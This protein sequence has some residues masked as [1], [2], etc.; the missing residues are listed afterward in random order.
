M[1]L[2]EMVLALPASAIKALGLIGVNTIEHNELIRK[3]ESVTDHYVIA[4]RYIIEDLPSLRQII[5]YIIVRN[6]Q[7]QVLV[8]KRKGGNEK[9][10][11]DLY[12]FGV[13]GHTSILDISTNLK[14]GYVNIQETLITS[15]QRELK[16]EL[17]NDLL[18]LEA[19]NIRFQGFLALSES[20]VDEVHLGLVAFLTIDKNVI[21]LTNNKKEGLVDIEWVDIN[22]LSE[23]NLENWSRKSLEVGLVK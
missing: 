1:G 8:Y 3:L 23:L 20:K 13:G 4:S 18:V 11:E 15:V 9:R 19:F 2:R 12:S 5:P 21:D 6:A 14:E 22:K 16:E 10:L 17:K 7:G